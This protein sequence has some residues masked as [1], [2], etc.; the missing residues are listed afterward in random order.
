MMNY[1]VVGMG[2]TG[3]STAR[4]LLN[5]GEKVLG[6]DDHKKWSDISPNLLNHPAFSPLKPIDLSKLNRRKIQECIVSP[7]VPSYHPILAK[8]E[9]ERIPIV[10]EVE[11][12]CRMLHFPLIGITG[13]NGKSTTVA[14]IGHI[15][16]RAGFS[17]FVGGNFGT[18]LIDS[19]S[20][21]TSYQ[22]GVVELS[23]FQLERILSARFQIAGILNLSPNHL[24]R[25]NT[26][27]DY[28]FQ[29]RN[30]FINQKKEDRAIVNFS[31]PSWHTQ[32]CPMIR[33]SIIPVTGL[34]QLQEGFY[35]KNQKIVERFEGKERKIDCLNW[36]LP[37]EHN[38]ENLLF[39]TAVCRVVGV[40]V[41]QIEESLSTFQ[42]LSHRIQKVAE[43]N[44]VVFY[45]DSKS[46]TPASTCA[47]I[48]SLNGPI[49]LLLGGRSKIKD[50]SEFTQ[51]LSPAKIKMILLFGEDRELIQKFIPES[52]P[53]R[54]FSNLDEIFS[55]IRSLV[56]P[57]DCVLLSPACT[58]W[59]QYA[60]YQERGEHFFR[61]VYGNS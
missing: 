2:K 40:G 55:N 58:S 38:R 7:G 59:D 42:G 22:W 29:K 53:T 14:L 5:R 43:I 8:C 52:I 16:N 36:H 6:Y 19:I 15:M 34:G 24:D 51:Y 39:A 11:L 37:G 31:I 10:S 1:L 3:E 61:L 50:F 54:L 48:N 12:A 49:V 21:P 26:F 17:V 27:R 41:D 57:G 23:S 33:S 13:S 35:W 47:A 4:F 9:Q 60:N 28:F 20:F 18:P 56:V 30:I 46:T 45:D 25:H 32:L 44:G